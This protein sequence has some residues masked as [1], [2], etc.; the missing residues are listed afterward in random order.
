MIPQCLMQPI[1]IKWKR[2]QYDTVNT[3]FLKMN[4]Y[5]GVLS[6]TSMDGIDVAIVNVEEHSV[7]AA[8]T[9]PYS[10][11]LYKDLYQLANGKPMPVTEMARLHRMLG[12]EFAGACNR[13]LCS[14]EIK[15]SDIKA[16]GSH[17]Q[18]VCHEPFAAPAYT[19]QLGCAHTIAQQTGIRTVADFRSGDI[20]AG[21]QGA[22]LAPLY[23]KELFSEVTRPYAVVNI[24]GIA[25]VS[26][27]SDERSSYGTDTGPGNV[28]L[29]AWISFNNDE[30][31]DR[32][33]LWAMEGCQLP[34]L[35]EQ[36]LSDP[37]FQQ[38]KPKSLDKSYFSLQWLRKFLNSDIQAADVQATLTHFT[39]KTI[40]NDILENIQSPTCVICCGGGVHNNYLMQCLEQYLP[41]ISIQHPQNFNLNTDYIEAMLFAWLAKQRINSR[42][43]SLTPAIISSEAHLFGVIYEPF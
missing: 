23:H 31:Y 28:L 22:P 1:K 37:Y 32:E 33:G 3:G 21:G 4:L 27:I 26:W 30:T 6:G 11:K 15:A 40:A 8:D 16:I 20:V 12:I 9:Y 5:M 24:G 36:L 19:L 10:A 29:D 7:I 39:A 42:K 41:D 13:L 17:G 25:N 18:T 34:E 43:I 2:Y 38:S 35:L 14:T